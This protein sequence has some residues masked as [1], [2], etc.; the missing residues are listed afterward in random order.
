MLG[1]RRH[2]LFRRGFVLGIYEQGDAQTLHIHLSPQPSSHP[3]IQPSSHPAIQPGCSCW[4]GADQGRPRR[5]VMDEFTLRKGHRD[6]TIVIC[7]DAQQVLWGRE[8]CSR[9]EVRPFFEGLG[10]SAIRSK[11]LRWI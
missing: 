6:E 9:A 1:Y 7:A 3:A 5:L 8:G 11:R 2:N 10:P 4:G